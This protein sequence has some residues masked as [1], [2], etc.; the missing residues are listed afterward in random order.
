MCDATLVRVRLP[1]GQ[2]LTLSAT[3]VAELSAH[4]D[5]ALATAGNWTLLGG[6]PRKPIPLPDTATPL[7]SVLS[8]GDA[9]IVRL[10]TVHNAT[11]LPSADVWELQGADEL[12]HRM[13]V[14]GNPTNNSNV[15]LHTQIMSPAQLA[16][17]SDAIHLGAE[18]AAWLA[19]RRPP[20]D[21]PSGD[22]LMSCGDV[23]RLQTLL[24]EKSF[25][26]FVA[27]N[28]GSGDEQ[29]A[30]RWDYLRRAAGV[31]VHVQQS[32]LDGL[33]AGGWT[34]EGLAELDMLL[35]L[36]GAA[37]EP[38]AARRFMRAEALARAIYSSTGGDLFKCWAWCAA[39][40]SRAACTRRPHCQRHP[41]A[42]GCA[43]RA[44][45]LLR[46][47]PGTFGSSS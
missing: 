12:A 17:G 25:A 13:E 26:R 37:V 24:G 36:Q 28:L 9:V 5:A 45:L 22:A 33:A 7:S 23:P 40:Q 41:H 29:A 30:R 18:D 32:T 3:T 27:V 34:T 42:H 14:E 4:I 10:D 2:Q 31:A 38:A 8:S 35:H 46:L 39:H 44:T 20:A 19:S 21:W 43:S 1:S 11:S 6:F 47:P 16:A 15:V